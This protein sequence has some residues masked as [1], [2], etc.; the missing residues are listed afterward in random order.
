MRAFVMASLLALPLAAPAAADTG[1]TIK[2]NVKV[3]GHDCR[4]VK[5]IART[6]QAEAE[7]KA[8]FGTTEPAS[9][10]LV[11]PPTEPAVT[12]G[13][14]SLGR[15]ARCAG[16]KQGF[17]F[18][19]VPPGDY[20]VTALVTAPAVRYEPVFGSPVAPQRRDLYILQPVSVSAA[21]R[22]VRLTIKQD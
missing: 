17:R 12:P 3:A 6:P 7:I 22:T 18:R 15:D 16:W 2:G 1:L 21:D 14:P 11:A 5:L 9:V 4:G 19:D 20:F 13:V 10:A 8:M